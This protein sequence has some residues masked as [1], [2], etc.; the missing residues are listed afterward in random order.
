MLSHVVRRSSPEQFP[1]P[2][3]GANCFSRAFRWED[4]NAGAGMRFSSFSLS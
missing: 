4:F 2:V 1:A 3:Y